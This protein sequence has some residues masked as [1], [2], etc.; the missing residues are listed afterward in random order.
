MP[1]VMPATLP[2]TKALVSMSMATA[3]VIARIP[4]PLLRVFTVKV[5][6]ASAFTVVVTL[7]IVTTLILKEVTLRAVEAYM[8]AALIH[9]AG[10][11][12]AHQYLIATIAACLSRA[13]ADIS[14]SILQVV[15]E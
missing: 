15:A 8:P 5:T 11:D 6:R 14:M 4:I 12:M 7:Q 13:Q 2:A 1:P 9:P 10:K 3:T